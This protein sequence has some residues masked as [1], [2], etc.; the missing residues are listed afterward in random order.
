MNTYTKPQL[1]NSLRI[2]SEIFEDDQKY[3][4][5]PQQSK[6]TFALCLL[7]AFKIRPKSDD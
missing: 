6:E 4:D 3:L 2:L 5:L 1:E 7:K